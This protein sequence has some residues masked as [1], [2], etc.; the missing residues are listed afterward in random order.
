MES[1]R[2]FS[3][4]GLV[5]TALRNRLKADMVEA[6]VILHALSKRSPHI[7]EKVAMMMRPQKPRSKEYK[8]KKKL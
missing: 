4:A 3:A 8:T 6:Q 5:N 7:W 1:E 2:L